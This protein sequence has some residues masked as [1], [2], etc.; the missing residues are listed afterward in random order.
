M[1]F[2]HQVEH[3]FCRAEPLI[4]YGLTWASKHMDAKA[5]SMQSTKRA[6]GGMPLSRTPGLLVQGPLAVPIPKFVRA[7]FDFSFHETP[8]WA[9]CYKMDFNNTQL[10]YN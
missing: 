3:N 1:G 10:N 9:G 5:T 8:T 4:V 6:D 7:T 2:T